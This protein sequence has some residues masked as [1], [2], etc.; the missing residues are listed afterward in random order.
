[1]A[2]NTMT[3]SSLRRSARAVAAFRG[4]TTRRRRI[5]PKARRALKILGHAI[6]YLSNEFVRGQSPDLDREG[7][8]GAIHILMALNR[9]IYFECPEKPT[10]GERWR[11]LVGRP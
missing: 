3:G 8:L 10:L 9:Q 1:M 5:G 4:R 6:E 2:A 11:T 7:Q